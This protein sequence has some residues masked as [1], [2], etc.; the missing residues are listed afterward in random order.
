M[1]HWHGRQ[2]TENL[3]KEALEDFLNS[4]FLPGRI[5]SLEKAAALVK[6]SENERLSELL[7][8]LENFSHLSWQHHLHSLLFRVTIR[9]AIPVHGGERVSRETRQLDAAIA[10]YILREECALLE[11]ALIKFVCFRRG[12][13][14]SMGELREYSILEASFDFTKHLYE[15]RFSEVH[16]I[17]ALVVPFLRHPAGLHFNTNVSQVSRSWPWR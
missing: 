6:S 12:Q 8:K 10:T 7:N 14:S 13:F 5:E 2:H 4:K 17:L 15:S 1:S 11:L 16:R 3:E 9:N